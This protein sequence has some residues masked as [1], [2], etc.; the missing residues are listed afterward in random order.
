MMGLGGLSVVAAAVKLG[1]RAVMGTVFLYRRAQDL[2][3]AGI[4]ETIEI[5]QTRKYNSPT[6]CATYL[7][8][9]RIWPAAR[10]LR[11]Y[12]RAEGVNL[13]NDQALHAVDTVLFLE[14]EV[15]F[16]LDHG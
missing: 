10:G 7:S 14:P 13:V 4:G 8:W 12:F 15:E 5:G 2:V 3:P 1:R 9:R 16:L 11:T 6:F